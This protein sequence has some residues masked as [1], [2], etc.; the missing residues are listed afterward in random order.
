MSLLGAPC[1]TAKVNLSAVAVVI[2]PPDAVAD[3]LK[4]TELASCHVTVFVATPLNA[5]EAAKPVTVPAPLSFAK[6][7]DRLESAPSFSVFPTASTID[8]DTISLHDALPI[9]G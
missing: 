8:T 2:G 7:T 3:A 5:D 4:G 6:V 1:T 9:F